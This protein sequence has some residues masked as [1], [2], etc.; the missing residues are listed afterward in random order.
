MY[1]VHLYYYYYY[2]FMY[3]INVSFIYLYNI[4]YY[5]TLGEIQQIE[6]T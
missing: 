2:I 4:I 6:F 5:S 3:L 1:I